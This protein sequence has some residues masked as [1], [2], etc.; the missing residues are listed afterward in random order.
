MIR[1]S[2]GTGPLNNTRRGV[3]EFFPKP[4]KPLTNQIG[5]PLVDE[6]QAGLQSAQNQV[7][8]VSMG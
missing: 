1:F 3:K 2:M 4:G 5:A 8:A 6:P 7:G